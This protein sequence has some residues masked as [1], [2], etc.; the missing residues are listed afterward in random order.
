M[1]IFVKN[2][3]VVKK[4]NTNIGKIECIHLQLFIENQDV[5]FFSCYKPP[6]VHDKEFINELENVIYSVDQ[7]DPL[8]IVGDLNFNTG[9]NE[10]FEGFISSNIL[11]NYV[12]EPTR[13]RSNYSKYTSDFKVSESSID[14]ILHNY[15][16]VKNTSTLPCSFSDHRFVMCNIEFQKPEVVRKSI[17]CRNLSLKNLAKITQAINNTDFGEINNIEN[18]WENFKLLI[19]NILDNFAPERLITVKHKDYFPW[20]DEEL[21]QLKYHRDQL[22]KNFKTSGLSEDYKLFSDARKAYNDLHNQKLIDYFKDK[23]PKDFQSTKKFYEFYSSFI[24]TRKCS[25]NSDFPKIADGYDFAENDYDKCKLFNKFFTSIKTNSTKNMSE[26]LDFTKNHFNKLIEMGKLKINSKFNFK[27]VSEETVLKL[28][29]NLDSANGPGCTMIPCKVIKSSSLKLAPILTRMFNK[30]ICDKSIPIDW[31]TAVVTPLFKNKGDAEDV[32]NYR[33]ISVIPPIAKVFEKLIATQIIEHL[34]K[35]GILTND[36]HGFRSAHSC[37]TALHQIISH[38]FKVLSKRQ[39]ALF[40]FVDFKKAFD[41]IES[42]ILLYKLQFYG[43]SDGSIELI[44]N[45]FTTRKQYVKLNSTKSETLELLLGVP[46]GSILGPLFF[47]IFIND[48]SSFIDFF[49]KL[50][51]D[52]TT[53]AKVSASLPQLLEDFNLSITNLITWCTYNRLEINWSKTKAMIITN[54]HNTERPKH[55]EING[56]LVEVVSNFKLLGVTLDEKLNFLQHVGQ[57]RQSINKRLFSIKNIFFLSFPVKIQFFKS[58][59]LPYFDYCST[60]L[61]YFPKYSVQ[62]IANTYNQCL[63]RLF[64]FKSTINQLSDFNNFN[65]MLESYKLSNFQ[66]RILER[67]CVFIYK[68]L[69]DPMSPLDLKIQFEKKS[70]VFPRYDLRKSNNF[71]IPSKGKFNDFGERTFSYFYSKFVN[72]L[73]IDDLSLSEATFKNRIK[74]NNNL[75]FLKF[76]DMFENFDIKFKHFI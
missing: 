74:I 37:E 72:H 57:L 48:M 49:C 25:E 22:H 73:L 42:I 67:L 16:L 17:K 50:F 56:H 59:I 20:I 52:D 7:S 19:L 32:N 24:Q 68:I 66:H 61:I 30:A 75:L 54:K 9:S 51:A 28:I 34:E 15:N 29:N 76:V 8:F 58:F 12:N 41:T 26:C 21:L 1:L 36:Q 35:N 71:I 43:F 2:S 5:N 47:L 31:K 10:T 69:S 70:N 4:Y 44:K 40:L 60:L 33:G 62:K 38:M 23:S 27:Q 13:I 45:Y 18:Y 63:F 6:D 64:K 3:L 39:I 11:K 14:V 55:I 53:L 46:Q 65:N